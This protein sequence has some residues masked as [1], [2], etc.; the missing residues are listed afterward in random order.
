MN[1]LTNGLDTIINLEKQMVRCTNDLVKLRNVRYLLSKA[2]TDINSVVSPLSIDY[3]Q[4]S[5]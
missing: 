5:D 1:N 4:G 3:L 2:I